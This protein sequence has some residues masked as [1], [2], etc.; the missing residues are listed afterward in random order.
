MLS[1]VKPVGLGCA[2]LSLFHSVAIFIH[3]LSRVAFV[4]CGDSIGRYKNLPDTGD[5]NFAFVLNK[6]EA[7]S[8]SPPFLV[9]VI[10]CSAVENLALREAIRQ[11]WGSLPPS[12]EPEIKILF[13]LGRRRG[14]NSTTTTTVDDDAAVEAEDARYGDVIQADFVDSYANLTLKSM[15]MLRWM[16]AYCASA[17]FLLK[18][19][20][21]TFVNTPLL[22]NDLRKTVHS[23]FIMGNI[24]A[25]AKPVRRPDAKWYTSLS[26]FNRTVYP[27]YVSGAAYVVSGD[28]IADLY[29]AGSTLPLFWIEDVYVTGLLA[30]TV[31][32]QHIFNG[33]FD[34]F[35]DL[36]DESSIRS[37]VVRH[38]I[39]PE[40]LRTLWNIVRDV[41]H[42][43]PSFSEV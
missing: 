4:D 13:L 19:D 36:A 32:L 39:A 20:D 31:R 3:L 9:V 34:G 16:T 26:A 1:N 14:S 10:V 24:I 5:R 2:R 42:R 15:T 8:R 25:L 23:R 38:R 6:P 41:H 30:R 12:S 29:S 21:D 43:S 40:R 17:K 35:K 28:V 7:C 27:T 37:H 11:T 18:S 33:K 22:L